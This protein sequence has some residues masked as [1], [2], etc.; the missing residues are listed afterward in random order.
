M[1]S[2]VFG[3]SITGL[4][5]HVIQIEA[6][7]SNGLP[8][9]HMVGFLASAVKEARERVRVSLQ[10]AGYRFPAKRITVS[11]SPADLRK[12]GSG[13]DLPIAISL[14]AAF[15]MIPRQITE[16]TM[17]AGELGL[18]GKLRGV[19]G[20]LAMALCAKKEGF[21][22][23]VLPLEN[24]REAAMVEGLEV[25]GVKG[26]DE[27]IGIF[28]GDREKMPAPVAHDA[29]PE[30]EEGRGC[31][32]FS[33]VYGQETVKRALE[34]AVSGGH[35]VLMIGAPGT[36]KTMLAKRIPGIMPPLSREEALELTK[37]YSV[38]GLLN[39]QMPVVVRRPFRSPH[40]TIT[41]AA[42]AG[43]GKTP[44][45]GELT[46]AHNGVL[47]LDELPEFSRNTLE[48]LRQPMEDGTIHISRLGGFFE[49]PCDMTVVGAMNPCK[50]GYYPDLRKCRCT[51]GQIQSYLAR[52]SEPLLD[53]IDLCVEMERPGHFGKGKPGESSAAIRERIVRTRELQRVRYRKEAISRNSQL[54]GHLLEKYC[55]LGTEEQ[56]F[57]EELAEQSGVSLRGAHRMLRVARTLAD[58]A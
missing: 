34:T 38:A 28:R 37:I 14:L 17:L 44:I 32:D 54:K 23:F 29:L 10:N 51:T 36:G 15:G 31:P 5:A 40:H 57:F 58:M 56:R 43:G 18:D 6:D 13:F 55:P 22:T 3:A 47:F 42:L 27:V 2:K 19:H 8:V 25:L 46:L 53:R 45:P 20:A 16:K 30:G 49:Y 39:E 35:N 4:E 48:I 26:L 7:V 33:E 9:F 50:C 52:L 21:K 24:A 12:D 41:A 1:Y 11:L